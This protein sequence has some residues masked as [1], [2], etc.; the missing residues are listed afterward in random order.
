[1]LLWIIARPKVVGLALA[2]ALLAYGGYRAYEAGVAREK[3]RQQ[4]EAGRAVDGALKG[5]AEANRQLDARPVDDLLKDKGWVR[6]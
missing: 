6:Q 4:M 5:A 3:L 1:V 2:L